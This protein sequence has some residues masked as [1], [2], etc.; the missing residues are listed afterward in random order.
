MNIFRRTIVQYNMK[1]FSAY[2]SHRN[3]YYQECLTEDFLKYEEFMKTNT[4][5]TYAVISQK[6]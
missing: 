4:Y 3:R 2:F 1:L 5:K 6:F